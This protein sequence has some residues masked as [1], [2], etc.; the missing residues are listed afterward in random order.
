MHNPPRILIIDDEDLCP[1]SIFVPSHRLRRSSLGPRTLSREIPL[2]SAEGCWDLGG[3]LAFDEAK[4]LRCWILRRNRN[5]HA[6]WSS[7]RCPSNMLLSFCMD[8][9]RTIFSRYFF[10][11]PYSAFFTVIGDPNNVILGF[12]NCR[13]RKFPLLS[14]QSAGG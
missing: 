9:S 10:S 2:T 3:A 4:H 8:S 5:D 1:N 11:S 6:I 7:I 13:T 14:L 12:P